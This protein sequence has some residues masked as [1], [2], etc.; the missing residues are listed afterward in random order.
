MCAVRAATDHLRRCQ[1]G[2]AACVAAAGILRHLAESPAVR[3]FA[4]CTW[5]QHPLLLL[6]GIM[7]LLCACLR[8]NNVRLSVMHLFSTCSHSM[9]YACEQRVAV[10]QVQV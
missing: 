7:L 6:Q 3:L 8:A 10:L 2:G 5:P 1:A 4:I 9:L